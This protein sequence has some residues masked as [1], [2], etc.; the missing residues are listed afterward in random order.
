[1]LDISVPVI[2]LAV[3]IFIFTVIELEMNKPTNYFNNSFYDYR[4]RVT[5]MLFL[6]MLLL[7]SIVIVLYLVNQKEYFK[8]KEKEQN[9][10]K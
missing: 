1:M 8:D 2:F 7:V 4:S 3:I 6:T 5:M 9:K 10:N